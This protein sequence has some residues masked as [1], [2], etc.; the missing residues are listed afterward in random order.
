MTLLAILELAR[1]KVVRVLQSPDDETLFIT[2]V[3]ERGDRGGDARDDTSVAVEADASR[4]TRARHC[5]ERRRS[6][7]DDEEKHE[8]A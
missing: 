7:A 8:E 3:S 6:C 1:L 2:Q 5:G 4:R